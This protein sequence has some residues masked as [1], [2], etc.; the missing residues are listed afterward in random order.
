M[1]RWW[2]RGLAVWLIGVGL[3]GCATVP[4]PPSESAIATLRPYQNELKAKVASGNLTRAQARDLLYGKLAEVQPPLPD[5][6]ELLEFRK[7]IES[8]LEAKLLGQEEAEAVL[9]A[10]ESA[11]LSR[12]EEMAAKYEREEREFDRIRQIQERG[13]REEQS[14][15]M[16]PPIVPGR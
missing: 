1:N 11:M 12:W 3:M 4:V 2:N 14:P 10:R 5:L 16:R 8:K 13:F 9:A 6:N 7:Q 15:M